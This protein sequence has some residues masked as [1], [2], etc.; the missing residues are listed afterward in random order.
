LIA[1]S[2]RDAVSAGE[3]GLFL[4]QPTGPSQTCTVIN[5]GATV[6]QADVSD[7][8]VQ[9]SVNSFT[10]GGTVSGL[11][12]R[13]LV[14]QNN[15]GDDLALSYAANGSFSFATP[16]ASGANYVVTVKTQPQ[17]LSQ[18]CNVS[19]GSGAV[20]TAAV[21]TVVVTCDA[22]APSAPARFAYVANEYSDNVSAYTIDA[23]TGAL[24]PM[25]VPTVAAGNGPRSVTVDPTG[26]FAYVA[27]WLSDNLSA[28]AI[29]A[30]TGA[31]SPMTVPTAAAGNGP[32]S[33]TVDPTGRFAYV[34]NWLSDN[35]SA[36]AIDAGTGALSP[37]TVPTVA[38]GNGPRSISFAR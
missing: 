38:A 20:T 11:F 19:S 9:C 6:A 4:A 10:V 35:V 13:G 23:G 8:K 7:V 25:T 34:A 31:L 22:P 26:R 1:A 21:G 24:S 30:G 5:A 32:L 2:K 33:V 17:F 12:G 27:N 18:V 3:C 15:A 28:Y 29:D 14:L 36:Y 16:V 37:M